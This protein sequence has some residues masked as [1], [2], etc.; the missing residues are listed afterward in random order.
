[1]TLPGSHSLALDQEPVLPEKMELIQTAVDTFIPFLLD[2]PSYRQQHHVDGGNGWNKTGLASLGVTYLGTTNK[3]K[4]QKDEWWQTLNLSFGWNCHHSSNGLCWNIKLHME[5]EELHHK[6][7][8]KAAVRSCH[9]FIVGYQLWSYPDDLNIHQHIKNNIDL[10][11]QVWS[12]DCQSWILPP[13]LLLLTT[14]GI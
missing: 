11:W 2:F 7:Y 13:H 4:K 8:S 3:R 6:L 9:L 5:R 12:R 1:M 14:S 10:T